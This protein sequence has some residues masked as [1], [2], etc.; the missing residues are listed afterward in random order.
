MSKLLVFVR[1]YPPYNAGERASFE[2]EV[3]ADLIERK[4]AK[5][6]EQENEEPEV[7]EEE[8]QTEEETENKSEEENEEEIP[9]EV[10][11][12]LEEHDDGNGWYAFPEL[13]KKKRK[14]DAIEYIES[15]LLE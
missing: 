12:I 14:D 11:E 7:E 10:K 4:L 15:E 3:A 13:D 2:D 1:S 8:V 6:V 9:E 5:P